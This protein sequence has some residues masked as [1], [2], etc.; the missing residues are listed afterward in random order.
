MSETMEP[1]ATEMD[2]QELAQQLLAQA[3]EQGIELVGPGGLLNRLTKNVLET[4]LEAEMDEHLGY[5]KHEVSGR[6]SGNSRARGQGQGPFPHRAGS[7]Q[8][9]RPGD[10][11]TGPDRPRQGTMGLTVEAGTERLRHHLRRKN[12]LNAN[13]ESTVKRTLPSV[14]RSDSTSPA[15]SPLTSL[16]TVDSLFDN[17]KGR[18][19]APSPVED[20]DVPCQVADAFRDLWRPGYAP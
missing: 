5:G 4:A 17:R 6:G 14:Q 10:P 18:P 2:Q 13:G 19:S 20:S 9:P 8:M 15:S 3:R 7:P 16:L 12:Q 11:C 1:M